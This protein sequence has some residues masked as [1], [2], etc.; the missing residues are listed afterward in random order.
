MF[1]WMIVLGFIIYWKIKEYFNKKRNAFHQNLSRLSYNPILQNFSL[2]TTTLLAD[3]SNVAMFKNMYNV[4]KMYLFKGLFVIHIGAKPL[5][6]CF[7]AK[8][9]QAVLKSNINIEKKFPYNFLKPLL[10][11]GLLTSNGEKW[12]MRRKLLTPSFHFR[13][14]EDFQPILNKNAK[15]LVRVLRD[16]DGQAIDATSFMSRCSLDVLCETALGVRLNS[17][18]N[19]DCAYLQGIQKIGK[20]FAY[21]IVRP[22]LW[23]DKIF[24]RTK[25]GIETKTVMNIINDF[26]IKIIR[27]RKTE[28]KEIFLEKEEN[29]ILSNGKLGLLDLLLTQEKEGKISENDILEEVNAFMFAGHDTTAYALSWVLYLLGIHLDIQTKVLEEID[30]IFGDDFDRDISMEDIKEM[31]YLECVI[32]ESLR[33]F[34]SVPLFSRN[35]SE[36]TKFDNYTIPKG[37]TCIIFTYLLHRNPYS[38][39]DPNT[40]NPDRFLPENSKGRHP[41]SFIPFSA[42]SR[43]CIGQR[44]ALMEEKII[45]SHLLRNYTVETMEK[46]FTRF[47]LTGEMIL[48]PKCGIKLK[49]NERINKNKHVE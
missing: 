15:I 22:W 13:I 21:R 43:N 35:L 37:T 7:S 3:D 9:V 42:G 10:K 28:L 23:P 46:D 31:K 25:K 8:S 27:K 20:I 44:L 48:R 36:D 24:Y 32:K 29:S 38:F 17:M 6:I 1:W 19:E 18:K 16:F 34:P 40:F 11:E 33:L 12:R 5:V 47:N 49:L 26:A 30:F 45:L 4:C 14:L 41:Y 2:L 39:F